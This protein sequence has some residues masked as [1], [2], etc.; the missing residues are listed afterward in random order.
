V[1]LHPKLP[2]TIFT[3]AEK[4]DNTGGRG[5]PIECNIKSKEDVRKVF[6]KTVQEFSRI[7]I[8]INNGLNCFCPSI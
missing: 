6:R 3:T 2:R 8:M 5:L 4:I 1:T 7:D